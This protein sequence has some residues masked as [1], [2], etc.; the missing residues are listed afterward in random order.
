MGEMRNAHKILDWKHGGKGP[1]RRPRYIQEDSAKMDLREI[2]G[3][4]WTGLIW[5]RTG[6]SGRLL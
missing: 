1:L 4:V 5:L 3:K 2:S 6:T